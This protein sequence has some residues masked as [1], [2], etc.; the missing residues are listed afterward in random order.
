MRGEEINSAATTALGGKLLRDFLI[1]AER[2]RLD[3]SI[4]SLGSRTESPFERDVVTELTLRGLQLVP[5]VGVAGYRI[6]LG[7][8]DPAIPGRFICGI[9]CDG[10]AYHSSETAR[11]RDRLRQQVL[12]ARGWTIHRLWSTSW[13]LDRAGQI[14]RLCQ[15]VAV[16]K[17]RLVGERNAD[18]IARDREAATM[19]QKLSIASEQARRE[20]EQARRQLLIPYKRMQAEP[21]VLTPFDP[22]LDRGDILSVPSSQIMEAIVTVIEVE[23]PIHTDDLCVRVA[24]MWRTKAGA[25]IARRIESMADVAVVSKRVLR[26]GDFWWRLDSQCRIRSRTETKTPADRIAPQE[27]EM[28]IR[29]VLSDGHGF[30]RE[31]LVTE[32]RTVLGYARTG[33]ALEEAIRSAIDGLLQ[34]NVVGEGSTG[35]KLRIG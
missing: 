26:N 20:A 29:R 19:V 28:I 6:D 15:L 9:E 10:A 22:S 4:E 23:G 21:Y 24:Q 7:V 31:Q 1:Y 27:Y 11:D 12:E 3:S 14:D 30:L 25:K 2:G 32:I 16:T 35:I 18:R 5:Q 34:R 8:T 17:E 13:F 33:A